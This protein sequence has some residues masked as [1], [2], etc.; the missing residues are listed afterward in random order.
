MR[1]ELKIAPSSLERL[2]LVY[3]RNELL[4][5]IMQCGACA[6]AA[7]R[8]ISATGKKS[9]AQILKDLIMLGK[10]S[11]GMYPY[12]HIIV[13]VQEKYNQWVVVAFLHDDKLYYKVF[14]SLSDADKYILYLQEKD[15]GITE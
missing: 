13:N 8:L 7:K 3:V 15:R 5:V 2:A 10:T 1:T 11:G 14:Y 12:F 6:D 9:H 4:P